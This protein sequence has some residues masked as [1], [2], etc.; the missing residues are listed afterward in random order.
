MIALAFAVRKYEWRRAH[1][2]DLPSRSSDNEYEQSLARWYSK[3]SQRQHRAL[4]SRPS[5]R[6]LTPNE[7]AHLDSIVRIAIETPAAAPVEPRRKRL[8]RKSS[9]SST[10][11]SEDADSG[12]GWWEELWNSD[13]D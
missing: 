10:W 11:R 6:Q 12:S 8:R 4:S 7:T 9:F 2:G 5:Q 3:A 1:A 13:S